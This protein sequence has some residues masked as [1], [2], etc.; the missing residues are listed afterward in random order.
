MDDPDRLAELTAAVHALAE[1]NERTQKISAE[2]QSQLDT[3]LQIL[4]G[5]GEL[6]EGHRELLEKLRARA[7]LVGKPR[8]E[9]HNEP[10]KYVVQNAEVDCG[11]RMHLCHGRCCTFKV[12]LARQDL[13]EGGLVWDVDHPY[14]LAKN[15]EGYCV[16]QT[17]ETGFC[18][19]YHNR[20]AVCRSYSCEG[21]TR[22]WID[23]EKMI[24]APM[25]E[26]LVTIR[27]NVAGGK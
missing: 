21:D 24:P 18:G 17:R 25:A 10:D 20:P 5:R 2:L 7:Q 6:H 3:L 9:L 23:F 19:T 22:I 27:R 12:P 1:S 15:D 16:Y 8:I 13:A 11:A 14:R 4:I 26:G